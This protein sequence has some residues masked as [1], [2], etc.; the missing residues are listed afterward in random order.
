MRYFILSFNNIAKIFHAACMLSCTMAMPAAAYD[1][2]DDS[3]FLSTELWAGQI[4]FANT[5][6][7]GKLRVQQRR[8][9][10]SQSNSIRFVDPASANAIQATVNM[11]ENSVTDGLARARVA[12]QFCDIDGVANGDTGEVFAEI[13]IISD[14]GSALAV[15]LSLFRCD[16]DNCSDG[17]SLLDDRVTFGPPAL[18]TDHVLSLAFDSAGNA[19]TFGFDGVSASFGPAEIPDLAACGP[20]N[21]N[22]KAIGSRISQPDGASGQAGDVIALFDDIRVNGA[23]YD[24]FSRGFIDP[25]NW[26]ERD[27]ERTIL[28]EEDTPD[29]NVVRLAQ[30][31]G[32]A[33][34]RSNSLSF[35]DPDSIDSI[36]ASVRVDSTDIQ[37]P[38]DNT[39][40]V[41]AR[42]HGN[43]YND[44]SSAGPDDFSGDVFFQLRLI[45][46]LNS[47]PEY[48][49][50][51]GAFRCGD[52]AC[53]T[54]ND[55]FF[56]SFATWQ[57]G[58]AYALELGFDA[59][60]N[61]FIC[62]FE[63]QTVIYP[64]QADDPQPAAPA[65]DK[66][67]SLNT[68][69]DDLDGPGETGAISAVFD[70]VEVNVDLIGA[71][72]GD[73]LVGVTQSQAQVQA[74]VGLANISYNGMVSAQGIRPG[75]IVPGAA[76][77]GSRFI[78]TAETLGLPDPQLTL[79]EI[80]AGGNIERAA[81]DNCEQDLT[82]DIGKDIRDGVNA[83]LVE[84][85]APGLYFVAVSDT[86]GGSGNVLF[87]VTQPAGS[88]PA[89][90]NISYN[91]LVEA[92]GIQPGFIVGQAQTFALTVETLGLPDP[93]MAL[94]QITA[95]GNQ[96]IAS[97]DNCEQDLTADIGKDIRDGANACLLLELQPGAYFINVTGIGNS[98]GAAPA[99]G[100]LSD[101]D[102][103]E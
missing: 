68:R 63:D 58:E 67:K 10:I 52:A 54:G 46:D 64:L 99:R 34:G 16:N 49:V 2:F 8:G 20:S 102:F 21:R 56:E 80:T 55:I 26:N 32:E 48:T 39:G 30:R 100:L 5:V 12:G 69:I 51:C 93:I 38:N 97:N 70:D 75:F 36:R 41:R 14:D 22:F 89:L 76:P 25:V 42:L 11:Q 15:L 103:A 71:G 72:A 24:D 61:S 33:P 59:P 96:V 74:G 9:D 50:G 81:N 83:C 35:P 1:D 47:D 98:G 28:I 88:D 86:G 17:A 37:N 77:A 79:F 91:G 65:V 7:N 60:T 73:A 66:F 3:N 29:N 4:N 85:L 84:V 62:R 43:F 92:A 6:E 78:I 40:R 94:F 27:S 57:E 44:G 18:D 87:G 19:F 101:F 95:N 31:R 82:A 45:R 53:Q 13:G 23:F 90:L